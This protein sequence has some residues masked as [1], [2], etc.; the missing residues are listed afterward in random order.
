MRRRDARRRFARVDVKP[1]AL[2]G[3][4]M[5]VV[6][7]GSPDAAW[8]QAIPE[9]SLSTLF[10]VTDPVA[11]DLAGNGESPLTWRRPSLALVRLDT[12]AVD[13]DVSAN[14]VVAL[15]LLGTVVGDFG[16]GFLL[17]QCFLESCDNETEGWLAVAGASALAVGT[18]AAGAISGGGNAKGAFV[19]SAVGL[20]SGWLVTDFDDGFPLLIVI[21]TTMTALGALVWR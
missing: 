13:D 19:G 21:H 9:S 15:S 6:V 14:A 10:P 7:C 3:V 8:A 11:V 20:A 17:V 18:S 2:F 12:L 1:V 5:V 4:A 16:A